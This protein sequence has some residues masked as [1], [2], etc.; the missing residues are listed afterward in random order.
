MQMNRRFF[1]RNGAL[2]IAGTTAIPS[3]LV[4]SVLAQT[5]TAP[6][7]RLV[8]IFQ[9]GAADGLNIVVP[10]REKNYYSMRPSIA[11]P[12][13]QVLDL[14]GFFGLHP[15]LASFKPLYE[16]GH[17]AVVHAVGSPDMSRSHFDAQDY[18]ESGTPGLKSTQDG[19]LNR[20]L[21]VED[22][23]YRCT[24]T[25][26]RAVALGA[27]VPRTLAGSVPAIALSNLNSFA[28]GGRGPAP[29]PAASAFEAMYG[30]SGDRIFHPAGEETFEAV[31]ML[32]S[33]NPGQYTPSAGADY[34]NSEFGNNMKQIAQLLKA[35]L[36]VEAAFTDVSGWDTHQNQGSVNGQ[37]SNRLKDFSDSVAAFWR[38][39]GDSAAN[40]TLVTMSEFGRTAR[41][42][43]TGGTDH[44]HA[45]A[46]FVLGGEVKGG[47]VYGR[48]PGLANEQLNE[49]RDLALTT[50]YR[51]VLGE[52]VSRTLGASN[53]EQ[54]FPGAKLAPNNFLRLL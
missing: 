30:D 17:L 45:N 20:A 52:V 42:N 25:P 44:G 28:V 49:G 3:F 6:N 12:Q 27:D 51:E 4:R 33:A 39:L 7:R 48:W 34:P 36:G 21:Q 50:D 46:M 32:R 2:A 16:Q 5:V 1:L 53:L 13:N 8:V 19:W 24:Y 31:K 23:R 9:R 40:V 38:D 37:L 43:G 18:M 41:E 10:Y 54:V 47:K 11:I 22:A 15:S 14:D 29:S 35:N 26:F